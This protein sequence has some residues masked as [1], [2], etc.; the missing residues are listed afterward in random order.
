MSGGGSD[1]RRILSPVLPG[2]S[3]LFPNYNTE[4]VLPHVLDRLAAN[5]TYENVELVAVD[6]GSTDASAAILRRFCESG[7]FPGRVQFQ[8]KPNGGAIDTLNTALS[9]ATGELCVQLDSDASVETRGWLERMVG[10]METHDRVGVVTAKVVLDTGELHACGVNLVG[11]LGMHDRGS[12]PTESAGRR[13][14]H[15]R[16]TRAREGEGGPTESE[17]AEVDAG[18]GCCSIY[19]RN[20]ALEVGGYDAGFA[21]VWF[22]D[23]DLGLMI[24]TLGRKAFYL[25]DVRVVHHVTGRGAR[26]APSQRYKPSRIARAVVRRSSRRLSADVRA[27]IERRLGVDLEFH[28]DPAQKARMEHHYAY[29]QQKWG[30]DPVNP[31]MAA[32]QTR[33]RDTEVCWAT[34]PGRRAAGDE[35]IAAYNRAGA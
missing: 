27:S 15:H 35:I 24:R 18:I 13:R 11:P 2:V 28:F 33:W 4:N 31:D 6:D 8:E 7:A 17:I 26:V 30:W 10:F 5:T 12:T 1:P 32:I 22:D 20:D 25:P 23:L 29:W 14:W 34:D 9:A 19:R 21:P 3:L 16:V